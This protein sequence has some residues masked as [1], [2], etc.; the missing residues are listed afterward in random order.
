M[1]PFVTASCCFLRA[2]QNGIYSHL[3]EFSSIHPPSPCVLWFSLAFPCATLPFICRRLK[4]Y[5]LHAQLSS[6]LS[7]TARNTPDTIAR[8]R[9]PHHNALIVWVYHHPRPQYVFRTGIPKKPLVLPT[10]SFT[11]VDIFT[12]TNKELLRHTSLPLSVY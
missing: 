3:V 10:L 2:L 6:C 5:A 11:T 4:V 8:H 7:N 12:I 9:F 1:S